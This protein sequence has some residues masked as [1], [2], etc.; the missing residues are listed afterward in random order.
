MYIIGIILLGARTSV[1]FPNAHLAKKRKPIKEHS[2]Q[3]ESG[4]AILTLGLLG[5]VLPLNFPG[6]GK[7][8]RRFN[9]FY[10]KFADLKSC[11]NYKSL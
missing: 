11:N 5:W 1:R 7:G 10:S 4:Q 2:V 8:V 6:K 3:I 9:G